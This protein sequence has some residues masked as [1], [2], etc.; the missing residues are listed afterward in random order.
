MITAQLSNRRMRNLVHKIAVQSKERKFMS[1]GL[2]G[3]LVGRCQSYNFFKT[4]QGVD[5]GEYAI[6]Q[7][8]LSLFLKASILFLWKCDFIHMEIKLVSIWMVM[9]QASLW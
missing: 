7:I 5:L 6:F 2:V 4:I 3:T 8:S 1:A 9:H